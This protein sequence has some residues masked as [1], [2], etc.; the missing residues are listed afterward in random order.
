MTGIMKIRAGGEAH[1]RAQPNAPMR[2][3]PDQ[4]IAGQNAQQYWHEKFYL[5]PATCMIG[6]KV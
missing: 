3:K 6:I 4:A 5:A 2:Q 1:V